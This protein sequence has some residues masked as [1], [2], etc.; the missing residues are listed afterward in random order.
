M[1]LLDVIVN[2]DGDG[3]KLADN[4]DDDDGSFSST[5][6]FSVLLYVLSPYP[7]TTPSLLVLEQHLRIASSNLSTPKRCLEL[8]E[9][10]IAVPPIFNVH[11]NAE[12][13]C[14]KEKD[15]VHIQYQ[16]ET[17]QNNSYVRNIF[18]KIENSWYTFIIRY[19]RKQFLHHTHAGTTRRRMVPV[20]R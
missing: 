16:N 4:D 14:R 20:G 3:N 6:L 10:T 2:S 8:A 7:P 9:T 18:V 12:E 15:D 17:K 11:A 5:S 19:I 1:I 13:G